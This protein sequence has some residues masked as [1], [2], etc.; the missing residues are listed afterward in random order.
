MK[1]VAL[2]TCAQLPNLDDDER[3]LV[4]ALARVDIHAQPAV[5]DNPAVD[6]EA[7]DLVVV[8][9]T[10]DYAERCDEFLAWARSLSCVVNDVPLLEWNTD[11]RYLEQLAAAGV[12]TVH[13]QY[14]EPGAAFEP[15]GEPYVVKPSVSAGGRSSARFV[16]GDEDAAQTLVEQIHADRRTAMVQP[17]LDGEEKALVYIDGAYSHALRRRVPL[18][19]AGSR[20]VFYLDEELAPAEA[21]AADRRTAEAALACVPGEPSYARVDL[22]GGAV[23]ELELT[24]PSLYFEY[25]AGSAERLAK[26]LSR[27]KC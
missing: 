3:L 20:P 15:P 16:P 17:Y 11:K 14:V 7:F 24:E 18:P 10:W 21:S 13:T 6:W 22:L 25:G 2:A 23:L 5:W 12:A 26:A 27:T 4:P 9:S 8:R 1:R 19:A